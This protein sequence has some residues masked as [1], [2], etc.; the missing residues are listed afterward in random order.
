MMKRSESRSRIVR[1]S[2]LFVLIFTLALTM[3]GFN[4]RVVEAHSPSY[5]SGPHLTMN[6]NPNGFMPDAQYQYLVHANLYST[7]PAYIHWISPASNYASTVVNVVDGQCD[8][9]PLALNLSGVVGYTPSTALQTQS[10]V[11]R[12]TTAGVTGLVNEQQNINFGSG[13][14]TAGTYRHTAVGFNFVPPPDASGKCFTKDKYTVTVFTKSITQFSSSPTYRCVAQ[15]RN[16][17]SS[18]TDFGVCNEA[19]WTFDVNVFRWPPGDYN[20]SVS[21]D[22]GPGSPTN[23]VVQKNTPY[24][25]YPK[26]LNSG[27]QQTW[28]TQ[29]MAVQNQQSSLVDNISI[30][31]LNPAANIDNI[32]GVEKSY[33]PG[34]NGCSTSGTISQ[35]CWSWAFRYLQKNRTVDSSF[36]FRVNNSA[37]AGDQVC[38]RPFVKRQS[39]DVS[40]NIGTRVCFTV[41]DALTCPAGTDYAGQLISSQSDRN[42]DG[43]VDAGDC[44]NPPP[45]SNYPYL[46]IKG[47]NVI[48]GANFTANGVCT[49]DS[50]AKQAN[51]YTNGFHTNVVEGFPDGTSNA[52]YGVWASGNIGDKAPGSNTFRGNYGYNRSGGGV[53]S[54]DDIREG[55]FASEGFTDTNSQYGNFYDSS[56]T[57]SLPC[58]DISADLVGAVNTGASAQSFLTSPTSGSLLLTGNQSIASLTVPAGVKKTLIV[59]GDLTI[60]GNINYSTPY[61]ATTIPNV[62]IIAQNIYIQSNARS[63]DANLVAFPYGSPGS[64]S[65]GIIDTCSNMIWQYSDGSSGAAPGDWPTNGRMLTTSCSSNPSLVINGSVIA[66]RMLWKRTFGT[67]GPKASAADATCYYPNYSVPADGVVISSADTAVQRYEQCAAELVKFSPEFFISELS[68]NATQTLQPVPVST[69][70]LPPIN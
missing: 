19:G 57:P 35:A 61:T 33:N 44:N 25:L 6:P 66:R 3:L 11:T 20:N 22:S 40:V 31:N 53:G 30:S 48:S 23:S 15:P 50:G 56:Q 7:T 32:L 41:Q 60:Q 54:N 1:S 63:I 36:R 28:G 45:P 10:K 68:S 58:V 24:T 34:T 46:Q 70:E 39:I 64:Y 17:A 18:L 67:L 12:V 38:F 9:V 59:Q 27:P 37:S 51:I 47:N 2:A 5:P 13:Y 21:I 52:Q 42:G 26:V 14:N 43:V 62:K 55:L 65:K 69:L 16:T 49:L 8:S 4:S 29:L